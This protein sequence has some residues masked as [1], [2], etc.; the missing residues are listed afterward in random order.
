M[1]YNL[2][3][4]LAVVALLIL[5]AVALNIAPQAKAD[6]YDFINVLDNNG[7]VYRDILSMMA[8]GK[9]TCYNLRTNT[10]IDVMANYLIGEQRFAEFEAGIIII[11]AAHTMCPDTEWRIQAA[12]AAPENRQELIYA[13]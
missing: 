2:R 3:L 1:Q 13:Q 9:E 8:L 12:V 7:V 5:A 6:Q 4:R 11:A 10:E